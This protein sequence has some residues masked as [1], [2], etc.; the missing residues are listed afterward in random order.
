MAKRSR[1]ARK[2]RA[3]QKKVARAPSPPPDAVPA[4]EAQAAEQTKPD[5]QEYRYVITDLRQVA[6]LAAAMFALLI[7]LSFLIR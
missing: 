6:I 3:R 7:A 2:R 4:V 1:R 5:F